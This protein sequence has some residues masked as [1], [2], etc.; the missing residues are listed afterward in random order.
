ML[1]DGVHALDEAL[2]ELDEAVLEYFI[3]GEVV[4]SGVGLMV[5][6]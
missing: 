4:L 3:G 1:L 2:F 6:G 5:Q